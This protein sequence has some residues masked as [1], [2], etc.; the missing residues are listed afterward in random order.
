MSPGL[1]KFGIGLAIVAGLLA[2]SFGVMWLGSAEL[3]PVRWLKL[4]GRFERVS[5]E[6]LRA[7]LA[8]QLRAGYFA[9]DLDALRASLEELA[10]VRQARVRKTWPDTVEATVFEHVPFAR[11]GD[12]QLVSEH[13]QVFAA[14]P[15][16][17][18]AGL[19]LLRG[20]DGDVALMLEFFKSATERLAGT[21]LEI[22]ELVRSDRGGW[23]VRVDEGFEL[24]LGQRAPLAR[25][26]L[27]VAALPQLA[28]G[29]VRAIDYIDMR[30]RNGMAVRW[31][32]S[33]A[34]A[35]T[36]K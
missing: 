25:L 1:A 19:P 12:A 33:D 29:G 23:S 34:M 6:Q 26:G 18:I 31:R 20:P 2:T 35:W 22:V 3:T 7:Q 17:P 15:D 36:D 30:Y 16:H 10:W 27:L 24:R 9:A 13:G 28:H 5:A 14:D 11:W 21:G 4:E 32:E 8:P